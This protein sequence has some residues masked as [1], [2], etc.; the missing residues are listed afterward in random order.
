MHQPLLPLKVFDRSLQAAWGSC[1]VKQEISLTSDLHQKV[2]F[3]FLEN[4]GE[5]T[6]IGKYS[7]VFVAVINRV[8]TSCSLELLAGLNVWLILLR[9]R[10]WDFSKCTFSCVNVYYNFI[11]WDWLLGNLPPW[12]LECSNQSIQI[13]SKR[14]LLSFPLLPCFLRI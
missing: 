1:N 12:L 8:P 11:E 7:K 14:C 5:L 13:T 10:A 4:F 9:M 2:I 6:E 3:E